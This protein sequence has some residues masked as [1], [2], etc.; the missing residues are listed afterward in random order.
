MSD[1][2]QPHGLQ[3]AR[4]LCPWDSPGKNTG[5]GCHA[6]LQGIVPTQG[7]N[8]GLLHW[9]ILSPQRRKRRNVYTYLLVTGNQEN[10]HIHYFNKEFRT[11]NWLNG[12]CR[13]EAAE[14]RLWGK[15][16]K[17]L[18]Y[19][20]GWR[21]KRTGQGYGILRS[22]EEGSQGAGTRISGEGSL[23]SWCGISVRHRGWF[24]E[25]RDSGARNQTSG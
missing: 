4:L 14:S 7:S 15:H 25:H 23:P 1:S 10:K 21:T 2:L 16:R 19:S 24:S 3:P 22:R 6:L 9:W 17:Q 12:Y 18:P 13:T 11:Q 20:L 5:V 8:L